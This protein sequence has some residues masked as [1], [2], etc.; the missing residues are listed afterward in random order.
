MVVLDRTL[1]REFPNLKNILTDVALLVAFC[2]LPFEGIL[3]T[4]KW[5]LNTHLSGTLPAS[6]CDERTSQ[7]QE[8]RGD[9]PGEG[10][11]NTIP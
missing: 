7:V 2:C 3:P 1:K 11:V 8:V 5:Q 9:L 6:V 10:A 4:Q